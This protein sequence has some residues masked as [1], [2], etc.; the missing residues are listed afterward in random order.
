[1]GEKVLTTTSGSSIN[2]INDIG[3]IK[4]RDIPKMRKTIKFELLG[5]KCSKQ[6]NYSLCSRDLGEFSAALPTNMSKL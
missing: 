5:V 4:T 3:A 1:M 6:N 2:L